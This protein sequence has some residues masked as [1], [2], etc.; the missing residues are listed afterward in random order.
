MLFV[1]DSLQIILTAALLVVGAFALVTWARSRPPS[2]RPIEIAPAGQRDHDAPAAPQASPP[3]LPLRPLLLAGDELRARLRLA[4]TGRIPVEQSP[5]PVSPRELAPIEPGLP[6][7]TVNSREELRVR[8]PAWQQTTPERHQAP[9]KITAVPAQ[10]C[11]PIMPDRTV[12]SRDELRSRLMASDLHLRIVRACLLRALHARVDQM[13]ARRSAD[14]STA[15]P[16]TPRPQ[17]SLPRLASSYADKIAWAIDCE[18]TGLH[19]DDRIVSFGAAEI[20]GD[21]PT[22][23]IMYL[24]FD[25]GRNSHPRAREKH[26]WSDWVLRHQPFFDDYAATLHKILSGADLVVGHN[27]AFDLDFLGRELRDA[28]HAALRLGAYCTMRAFQER[29]VGQRASLDSC[30]ARI[31]GR[32]QGRLHGALEDAVLA[33]S[34]Y[35]WLAFGHAQSIGLE[36][37]HLPTNL[38]ECPP[39]PPRPWPS[40]KRRPRL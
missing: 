6:E 3:P 23:R 9:N 16:S 26:G 38:Q 39:E 14:E 18:T 24:V 40:R 37:R 33:M 27:L 13:C 8:I 35:R 21:T 20:R 10:P 22:G 12:T 19:G 2:E 29:F 15:V 32:R 28:G 25:P 31:G 17:L 34:L 1:L 7:G 4:G 36:T 30:V 5:Q 11:E